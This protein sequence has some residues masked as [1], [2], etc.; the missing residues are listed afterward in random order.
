[1]ALRDIVTKDFG[2]KILS[3]ALAVAIWLTVHAISEDA[4]R[5]V[6]PLSGL[7]TRTFQDVPVL[8]VSAAADVRESKVKPGA[9]QVTVSGKP[10]AVSALDPRLIRVLVDLTG[11]EAAQDLKKRVDV[12]TPPGI[13]FVSAEPAEVDVVVP[14]R[15][16]K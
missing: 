11:V 4:S 12:S 8:V 16:S 9:V 5:R 6:N 1:M 10:D 3:V 2:W 7:M 15:N 13:T 14:P